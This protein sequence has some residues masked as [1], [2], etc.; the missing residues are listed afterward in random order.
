MWRVCLR[1]AVGGR[2][3]SLPEHKTA[4]LVVCGVC[5]RVAVGGRPVSLPEYKTAC[6]V[7]CGVCV[8]EWL[9]VDGLCHYLNTR[10]RV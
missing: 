1:V 4:C 2:P 7:D 8:S 3:V 5:L 9:S 6:L 10:Q